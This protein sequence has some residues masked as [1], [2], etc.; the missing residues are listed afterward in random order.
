MNSN[1]SKHCTCYYFAAIININHLDLDNTLTDKK[2]YEI[3]LIYDMTYKT[4]HDAKPLR[5][6]FDKVD[7][8]IRNN[9]KTRYLASFHSN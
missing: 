1:K 7:G 5:I 9:D 6:T 3:I 2:S 4:H 8:Y